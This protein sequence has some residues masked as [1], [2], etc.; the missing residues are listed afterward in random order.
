[1][2]HVWGRQAIARRSQVSKSAQAAGGRHAIMPSV[3]AR[4]AGEARQVA[5][6]S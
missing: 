5:T 3:R 6:A 1:L 4:T 2:Q